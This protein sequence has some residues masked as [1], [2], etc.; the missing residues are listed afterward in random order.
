M[1]NA[2]AARA[3]ITDLRTSGDYLVVPGV[4]LFPLPE[5][6]LVAGEAE[7][8]VAGNHPAAF[9]A[10]P[11]PPLRGQ[12]GPHSPIAYALEILHRARPVAGAVAA[13]KA[14][15]MAA[16][17]LG[18]FMAEPDAPLAYPGAPLHEMGAH[19]LAREAAGALGNLDP[20]LPRPVDVRKVAGADGAV[21]AAGGDQ[22]LGHRDSHRRG[23]GGG[24]CQFCGEKQRPKNVA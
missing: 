5:D 2:P 15:Q 22:A 18:A 16:G 12:K 7:A 9:G 17:E 6:I 24:Y 10:A 8:V 3:T 19:L 13:V 4:F 23:I 20:F 11:L 1:R 21:D 14:F